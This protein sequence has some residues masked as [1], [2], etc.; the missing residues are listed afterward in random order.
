MHKVHHSSQR[1]ETDSNY[2]SILSVWDRVFG[3]YRERRDYHGIHYGLPG[4]EHE[5]TQTVSGLLSTP[6][7][8]PLAA[9]KDANN[10]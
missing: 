5:R 8:E 4:F 6:F 2:A 9:P 7:V 3:T 10:L 1:V